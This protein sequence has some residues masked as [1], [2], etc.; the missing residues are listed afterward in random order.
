M[1]YLTILFFTGICIV[2]LGAFL[3][4]KL[5]EYIR[6]KS[7]DAIFVPYEDEVERKES[8]EGCITAMNMAYLM[9]IY[10]RIIGFIVVLGGI[11]LMVY[12]ILL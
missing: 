8:L 12:K 10:G 4:F 2:L 11:F 6:S 9:F 5:K 3:C 1:I 7:Y